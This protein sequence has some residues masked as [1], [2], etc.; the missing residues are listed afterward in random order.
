[1]IL[2]ILGVLAPVFGLIVLGVWLARIEFLDQQAFDVLNRFVISVTMPVLTFRT[3]A[4]TNA[5]DLMMPVMIVAVVG[6][7]FAV[8]AL[9]YAIERLGGRSTGEANISGL[10]GCFSNV[11]FVGLPVALLTF[12][13]VALGPVAVT[14]AL[15]SAIVFSLGVLLSELAIHGD[16]GLATAFRR[17][18]RAVTRSPLI[19]LAVAGVLWSLAGLPLSG[20]F[21]SF[22]AMLAGAT[23]PCALVAIGL[24][25]AMPRPRTAMAPVARVVLMKL[26]AH[27]LATAILVL[28]LPPI[29]KPWGMIA[30]LMAAMP[31]GASSFVLAGGAGPRAMELSAWAVTLSTA[32]AAV[33]LIPML[34]LVQH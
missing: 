12:G 27:P 17:A 9:G 8:Y 19:V 1:M 21:D 3:L 10:A 25:M 15:Y 33:S 16:H 26:V 34:W 31:S 11:G 29:P 23:A 7:A 13:R 5:H 18:G 20:P 30:V 24:F 4:R 28:M 14:M 2:T 22:L 32:L 6:G